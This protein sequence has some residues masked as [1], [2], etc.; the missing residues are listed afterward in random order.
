M[1]GI[2]SGTGV[3]SGIDS[4]GII[5]QLL[6]IDARPKQVIQRRIIQIQQQQAGYLDINSK[7]Q[8]LRT[9][10]S[11]F[12]T[13]RTFQA[14]AATTSDDKVLTAT[15]Q[16]GAATG[17]FQ[18][19]VDRLVSSQQ[20]LS[21]GFASSTQALNA[22]TFTFESGQAR[23]DRDTSL[24]DLNG[25][26]GIKRGKITIAQT[27]G[28]TTTVDLSKAATVNDV[29]DAINAASTGTSP[30]AVSASV[31]GGRFV[32]RSTNGQTITVADAPGT[33]GTADSLGVKTA[34]PSATVNGQLVYRLGTSTSLASLN[35]GNGIY[36]NSQAGSGRFDLRI[37]VGGTNVDV[38]LGQLTDAAGA[39]TSPP[40]T[41]VGG[42]IER[43][44]AALQSR[45]GDSNMRAEIASDGR[46]LRIV[47]S[48]NRQ[49]RVVENPGVAGSTTARDLGLTTSAPVTG[50][51]TGQRILAGMNST[52]ARTL[53]GGS[54]IAGDGAISITTRDG[55]AR[56]ITIDPA[57]GISEI[58]AAIND[59]GAGAVTARINRQGTG[60]EIV[61][62][63][64][65]TGPLRITGATA[66]SLKINT[67]DGGVIASSVTGGNLQKQYVTAQTTLASLRNGQGV[68]TGA[69]TITDSLGGVK[70]ITIR[71]TDKT[72]DDV[73][74]KIN[75]DTT[76]RVKAR[77]NAKGDGLELYEDIAGQGTLKIKVADNEG[78]VA[79][80]LSVRGEAKGIG[81]QNS[82]DGTAEKQVTFAAADTLEQV[83]QKINQA[84]VGFQAAIINDG[85][86]STPFRMTLTARNSGV[87]GRTIVDTGSF[88]LGAATLDQGQDARV[89]YGSADPAS[90]VLLTSSR[91]TLDRVIQGVSI[92]LK[93]VS[94][95]PVTLSVS[96][97]TAAVVDG[98]N[99]FITAFN[100][101]NGSIGTQTKVDRETQRRAAL[102]GDST[103]LT[104][105][106]ELFALV[107][108]PTDGI[109]GRYRRLADVGVT[110][111]KDG[112][113]SLN[114]DRFRAALE[115][116]REAVVALFTAREGAPAT[117]PQEIAP[118]VT[119]NTPA[120]SSVVY[121][122]RGIMTKLDDL[123]NRYLNS[124]DGRLTRQDRTLKDQ[125]ELQNNRIEGIDQRLARRRAQLENQF[126]A[127]E[128]T[129]GRLQQQQSALGQ[130]G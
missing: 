71:D 9:A 15:A 77:I 118:G 107:N 67:P 82:I 19:T 30:V 65:G 126:R 11:N 105:R 38:N 80:N 31:E 48:S 64:T 26:N 5:N 124:V 90:A 22:G 88:D 78:S 110:V 44:N 24:S 45:L 63:T 127:M 104:L 101:L 14:A 125:I 130:I 96:N 39:V 56:S 29:L 116:D 61:D 23:L 16:A 108:A 72:M 83:V 59:Q 25:G 95:S 10:A 7:L 86:G 42:V 6:A 84:G 79:A 34:S 3:F 18:F 103:T 21:R 98:V 53:N 68:G 102:A 69:F 117:G 99:A 28:N 97:D 37:E 4:A 54:G 1:S 113:L 75:A 12:R 106:S 129:I 62:T 73:I 81:A 119:V 128:S 89:F 111:G 121:T 17:T 32:I 87:A 112:N 91:N 109:T 94:T 47:D 76:N 120:S 93:G 60:L 123:G 85:G 2:T 58:I 92:D 70:R 35:D 50:T 114:Q 57:S 52:L 122:T 40:V 115:T 43:I 20:L 100:A 13:N 49:F 33:T 41:T 46:S 66:E 8:S 36:F 27:G 51:L 55:T 74:R